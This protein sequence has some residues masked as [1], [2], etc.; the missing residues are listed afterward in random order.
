MGEKRNT[1]S[2]GPVKYFFCACFFH[3]FFHIVLHAVFHV[4]TDEFEKPRVP[5]QP[6]EGRMNLLEKCDLSIH[7]AVAEFLYAIGKCVTA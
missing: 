2:S 7:E 6:G 5:V 4:G 3:G 1:S